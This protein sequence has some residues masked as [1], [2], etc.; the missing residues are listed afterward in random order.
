MQ[1]KLNNGVKGQ[2]QERKGSQQ[3]PTPP[4]SVTDG[5]RASLKP[6]KQYTPL[7][8]PE[9]RVAVELLFAVI[10][11]MYTLSSAW[12]IRRTLLTAAK[13]FLLRPGNPSL[14]TVQSLIQKS[15]IDASTSDSGIADQLRKVRENMMP[16]EQE[17]AAWPAE[18][19]TD[20]KEQ[21]RI[22]ARRLLIQSGLPAALMGVMGQAATGEALGRVFDC[23]QIEEVARGLLFG[24]ILQVVR[25]VTH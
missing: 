6:A 23:L 2:Q 21:L 11:E 19:T 15:V 5:K 16:T 20:E 3:I 8:E 14:L 7:S 9:T 17:L 22:K 18:L 25:V 1:E 12:N 24:L 10:N 13:S 4:P